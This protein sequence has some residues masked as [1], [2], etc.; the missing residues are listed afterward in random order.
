VKKIGEFIYPWGNGHFTRMM[1]LDNLLE[2]NLKEESQIHYFSKGEIYK[3]LLTNFP[4]KK[5]YI[6]EVLMP[7]PIAGKYGPSVLKSLINL[8][9]PISGYP[10]LIKQISSYLRNERVYFDKEKFDLVISDGDVGANV[11]AHRRGITNLFLTNQFM[12]KLWKSKFYFYPSLVFISKQIAKA[13]K[14]IVADSPPPYT[15]CEYNLNFPKELEEKVIYA[16]HFAETYNG[17]MG[18]KTNLEK[19]IDG[20]SFGYWMRTGDRSTNDVTGAKFEEIFRENEMVVERRIVSHA[21]S[22]KNID[23]VIAKDGNTYSL[24]E[25]IEK[26]ID[27]IQIDIGFLNEQEKHSVLDACKYAV[28]NGSHT[29]IGEILGIKKKPIIGIPVYDEHSNNLRWAEEKQLGILIKNKKQAIN[30][31]MQIKSN[32]NKY[33]ENLDGFAQNFVH[34]GAKATSRIVT[35]ILDNK[36]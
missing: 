35:E 23:R 25:A 19:L 13:T 10:P 4:T 14:I 33:E 16:G 15:I 26:K 29:V 9:I 30:A 24:S 11:L 20:S 6:H 28:I 7:T 34:N 36:K 21:N 5:K 31:I 8:L 12:P 22:D 2:K 27:W 3:K 1:K 18:P 17:V 32:Y